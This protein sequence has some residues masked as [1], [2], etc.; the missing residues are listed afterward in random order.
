M[1][2]NRQS[3]TASSSAAGAIPLRPF[4]KHQ[5]VRISALGMGG[6]HLGDAKD[7]QTAVAL[8]QEAV[9][10]V[11]TFFD[12][13]WEY[14]RGKSEVWV[15]KGPQGRR[16]KVFLMTKVCTHGRDASL[17]MQML[18]QSLTR[19]HT[20]HLD[21]WQVHGVSF[22]NDPEVS[23]LG[24]G[25]YHLGST[26]DQQEANDLVAMALDA[27]TTFFDNAWD[28]HDGVSE[29]RLGN[30]LKGKRDQAFVM[31]KVCTHGRGKDVA[32]QMLEQS[33]RRLQ[34]DHLDLWQITIP[35]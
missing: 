22:E 20:D 4:G 34:T 10:G 31:T 7:E 25:G 17:A 9:D 29:E 33:L 8:V 18:E 12:N 1:L 6:H 13:C 19:L 27:G 3:N 35:I 32:M 15:G 5:D 30:A 11:I 21:L 26:R 24:V 14:H 23:A 28:Y 2:R 16:D